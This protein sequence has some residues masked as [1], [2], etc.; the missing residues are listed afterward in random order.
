MENDKYSAALKNHPGIHIINKYVVALDI[1]H[2]M[3]DTIFAA[4][5]WK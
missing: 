3:L 2:A 4:L 1:C 5:N